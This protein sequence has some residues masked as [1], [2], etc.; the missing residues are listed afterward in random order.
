MTIYNL[1]AAICQP[2]VDK[3]IIK[4]LNNVGDVF[5]LFLAIMASVSVMLIIGITMV[6]K[7]SGSG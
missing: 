3:K 2:V 7:I 4:L 5:K 6:I 1:G